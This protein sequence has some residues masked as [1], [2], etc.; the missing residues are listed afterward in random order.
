MTHLE[1]DFV[2]CIA[3]VSERVRRE[4]WDG[5]KK[6]GMRRE[7]EGSAITRLETLATQAK[8]FV[9]SQTKGKMAFS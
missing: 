9:T 6:K 7:G 1:K 4:S 3:S 5:S 2:A 8:D